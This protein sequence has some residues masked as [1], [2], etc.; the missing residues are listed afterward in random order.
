[1]TALTDLSGGFDAP[2]Q[3][4]ARAFRQIMEAMARPGTILPVTGARPPAPLSIAAGTV[5]LTLADATTPLH[6]AGASDCAE[7]RA[8][9]AFHV[10]APLVAAEDASLALGGWQDLQPA[11]R[12]AIGQPDY[13]DRSA[14]LIVEMDRL[15]A[16][17]ACLTGPGIETAAWLSL[18]E[19]GAFRAN[20]ALFPLGFDTILT[21]G[22]RIAA[23]PR[24]TRV[25][26]I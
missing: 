25:E 22:E 6:L 18:P 14:T 26:M 5:L 17:G 1:M 16:Q 3:Q 24:S 12:F 10:G 7:V 11:G 2:P 13:P 4:S 19:T 9:V 21:C 23:L 8:W 20:R 15:T